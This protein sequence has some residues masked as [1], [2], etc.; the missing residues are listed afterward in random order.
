MTVTR[1]LI[2][3][4]KDRKKDRVEVGYQDLALAST[5]AE[6]FSALDGVSQ[7]V[8]G[9]YHSHPHITAMPSHVDVKTQGHY[10]QLD[11][12]FIGLIFSVFDKGRLEICAFQSRG[13]GGSN[14]GD[15]QWATVEI[16][17]IISYEPPRTTFSG[18]HTPSMYSEN[19]V[20]LLA[21]LLNEDKQIFHSIA[22][23][24]SNSTGDSAPVNCDMTRV[25]NVYQSS[26]LHLM[27][28]Q[29]SPTLAAL[30]SRHQT[31]QRE[32]DAL[33]EKLKRR[34][35]VLPSP[36]PP[37]D[38][39]SRLSV[40]ESFTP[41]WAESSRSLRS[42]FEGTFVSIHLLPP[43]WKYLSTSTPHLLR[44]IP[45]PFERR[46]ISSASQLAMG[47]SLILDDDSQTCASILSMSSVSDDLSAD[48]QWEVMIVR[49]GMDPE[50]SILRFNILGPRN[51]ATGACD[52]LTK[53]DRQSLVKLFRTVL[54]PSLAMRCDRSVT[55]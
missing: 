13:S 8:V 10:Q 37:P 9:W 51:A 41:L 17:I 31:L 24:A 48:C 45:T 55:L 44:V 33:R 19:S 15:C 11:V 7:T 43:S 38:L 6:K 49:N 39:S 47:W 3:S 42:V 53:D 4:R 52:L 22:S 26:L 2:L 29:L 18:C 23:A 14:V 1:S 34:K 30:R 50:L 5:I 54:A 35:L 40:L 46:H 12:G 27:E 21:V 32:R 20:A 36:L 25:L 28:L 16:P